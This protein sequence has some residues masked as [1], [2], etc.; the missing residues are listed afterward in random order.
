[1]DFGWFHSFPM[2]L[3]SETHEALSLLFHQD[4]MPLAIICG[5]AKEMILGEFNRKLKKVSCHLKQMES[6]TTWLN[7]SKREIKELK[8]GSSRKLIKS[9]NPKRL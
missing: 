2:K 1:M 7:A 9:G 6:F 8:K 3:K 5:N 4:G